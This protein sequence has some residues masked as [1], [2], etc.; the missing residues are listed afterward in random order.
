[1]AQITNVEGATTTKADFFLN[2]V[3]VSQYYRDRVSSGQMT[4]EDAYAQF[5]AVQAGEIPFPGATKAGGD[6]DGGIGS[7]P[8][9]KMTADQTTRFNALQK[10]I[11]AAIAG[12][13]EERYGGLPAYLQMLGLGGRVSYNPA[14]QERVAQYN[15]LRSFQDIEQQQSL[16]GVSAQKGSPTLAEYM[17]KQGDMGP[18]RTSLYKQASGLL[19]NVFGAKPEAYNLLGYEPGA[20]FN[21]TTLENEYDPGNIKSLQ[22]LMRYGLRTKFGGAGAAFGA[23]LLPQLQLAYSGQKDAGTTKAARFTDWLKAKYPSFAF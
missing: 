10:Q 16:L 2:G 5:M 22:Q 19:G 13:T 1:M 20:K 23:D 8:I 18:G 7:V 15:P 11:D 3:N 4:Y 12:N 14:E 21:E 6:G 9:S 17:Q